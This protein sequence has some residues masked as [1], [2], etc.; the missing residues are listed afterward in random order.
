[1]PA[2]LTPQ[3]QKAEREFRRAQTA[4][5]KADCLQR[6]LQLIPRHKGTERLQADLKTRLKEERQ[7]IQQEA[8]APRGSAPYRIPRQGAGRIVIIGAPNCG[9]SR[10]LK[11]L[12]RAE[13]EVSPWPFTTREPLP[14][15]LILNDVRVQLID[16][17]PIAEG[18]LE[19]AMLNL[20]RT[21]DGVLLVLN[22]A[23][24]DAAEETRLVAAELRS[25]KT[26]LSR[27]SGF[28]EQDFSVFHV[29]STIVATHA[30]DPDFALRL[31]ML[32]D[33]VDLGLPVLPVELERADGVSELAQSIY[34][35]LEIVRVYTKRPGENP[36]RT[37][38][39]TIPQGGTVEDLAL[40]LHEDLFRSVTHARVWGTLAHDGQVVGRSYVLTDG[41]V[42][43]L[44]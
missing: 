3:Y 4:A 2:N 34:Q 37:D 43:E 33:G 13:P 9:K 6:M 18:Q 11:E 16:T 8:A 23:S 44:H 22:G 24:D 19:P 39:I 32:N 29:R 31:E 14:G 36:D 21:A 38:P 12:T 40:Q 26:Q 17:P 35:L 42:V 10:I 41:D 1:M 27:Q 5:E 30:D 20:V 25:R 15:M 28:D 7:K